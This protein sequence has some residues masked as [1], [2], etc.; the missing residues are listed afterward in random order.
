MEEWGHMTT[1][2]EVDRGE[3]CCVRRQRVIVG[4]TEGKRGEEKRVDSNQPPCAGE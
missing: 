1:M 2:R 3:D 4:G